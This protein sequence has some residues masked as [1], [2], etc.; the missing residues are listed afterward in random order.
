M[1]SEK[2]YDNVYFDD[3]FSCNPKDLIQVYDSG[4]YEIFIKAGNQ[5]RFLFI[6]APNASKYEPYKWLF[7]LVDKVVDDL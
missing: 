4:Y 3:M 2:V 1:R 7:N 6:K 5:R